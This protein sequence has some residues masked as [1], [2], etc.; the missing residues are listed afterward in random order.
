MQGGNVCLYV[1]VLE[2]GKEKKGGVMRGRK[3]EKH[4]KA[5]WFKELQK[6]FFFPFFVLL[7]LY[8]DLIE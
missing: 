2:R 4:C 6:M 3:K 7:A 1:D 8:V 5:L